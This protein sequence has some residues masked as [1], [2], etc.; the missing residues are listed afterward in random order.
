VVGQ[1]LREPAIDGE[2]AAPVP[3]LLAISDQRGIGVEAFEDSLEEGIADADT[4]AFGK[5]GALLVEG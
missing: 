3:V 1:S 2:G 4:L 5:L